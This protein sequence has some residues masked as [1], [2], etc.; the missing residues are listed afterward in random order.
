MAG[1]PILQG[2]LIA[3]TSTFTQLQHEIQIQI[4]MPIFSSV[5]TDLSFAQLGGSV[6]TQNL[7]ELL[8][9]SAMT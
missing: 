3:K 9:R 5:W 6:P 1:G 7:F 4:C 2:S 8:I